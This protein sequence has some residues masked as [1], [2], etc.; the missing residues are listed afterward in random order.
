VSF[1]SPLFLLALLAVP[2]AIGARHLAAHRARRNAIRFTGVSTLAGLVPQPGRWRRHLP[3]ALFLAAVATLALALA[4]PQRT[5]GVPVERASV[6][7]VTDVSRSMKADDVKPSRLEAARKAGQRFLDRA[8]KQLRIGSVTFSDRP[9]IV[10]SPS[11]DR[12]EA[13]S[14][15][16]GL[17]ADGGTATGD[18][19]A[20]ALDS[21]DRDRGKDGRRTPAAI[22]LLSDGESTI[23][24]DPVGVAREAGRK[25]IPIYTV[26]L[27][28]ES[29][30][31]QGPNGELLPVPPDPET[32]RR[33][34]KAS[35]GKAFTAT[36][37]DE[38][39]KVYEQLGS[40]IGQKREKREM[41]AGFAGVGAVL[42][43]LA[44]GLG[45]RFGGRLP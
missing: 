16:D 17:V 8:P 13:R 30:V 24:R 43:L 15:L 7:L 9:Q 3:L 26:A 38:L 40:R 19:L 11:G 33:I 44:A 2:A 25:N 27:G 28:T 22:L 34:A 6:T 10:E 18:G 35:N 1:A 23:G 41:T 20:A 31:V 42:I 39:D 21:L 29:A 37:S 45:L 4:K 5:V 36:Q 12:D 14:V 32:L